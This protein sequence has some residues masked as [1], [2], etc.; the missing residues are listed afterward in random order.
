MFKSFRIYLMHPNG[1][2]THWLTVDAKDAE[3]ALRRWAN[4]HE[5]IAMREGGYRAPIIPPEDGKTYFICRDSGGGTMENAGLF[6]YRS[7]T[8]QWFESVRV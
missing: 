8:A 4:K 2:A 7:S 5:C 3:G 6:R 1:G